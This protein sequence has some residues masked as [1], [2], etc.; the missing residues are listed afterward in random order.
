MKHVLSISAALL[1][2]ASQAQPAMAQKNGNLVSQAVAAEGGADALRALKGLSIRAQVKYWGPEQ[3]ETPGGEA[4]VYGDGNLTITW[5]LARGMARTELDRD[6]KYPA[7]EKLK[8]TETVTPT[9]GMLTNQQGANSAMSGVRLAT[10]LRE[11]TRASPTLMLTALDQPGSV[12]P[13]GPQRMGKQSMP[14]VSLTAGGTKFTVLF[15]SKTKLPAVIRTRDDDNVVGDANYDL[16][17]GDWK[18]VAAPRSRIRCPTRSTA[19]RFSGSPIPTSAPIPRSRPTPSTSPTTSSR[20][21]RDRRPAMCRIS[22]C[23]A[24]SSFHAMP[25]PMRSSIRQAAASSWSSLRPM[26]STCRAPAPTT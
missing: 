25:I 26:C 21:P 2:A 18:T 22:G 11:L 24:G 16:E 19:S 17:L 6:Q 20:R 10:H 9:M 5:D 4:R 8:Y 1:L 12:G 7:P 15:D 23:C 14:A 13:M 3:S